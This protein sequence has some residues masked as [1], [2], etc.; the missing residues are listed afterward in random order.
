MSQEQMETYCSNLR[1][2]LAEGEVRKVRT[3]LE[4]KGVND[5]AST[6]KFL[7]HTDTEGKKQGELVSIIMD[8]LK[9]NTV[10]V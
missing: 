9:S 2:F 8:T 3:H 4:A 7:G 1:K 5:L 6:V 10:T